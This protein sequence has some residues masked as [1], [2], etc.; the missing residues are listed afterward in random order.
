MN[1]LLPDTLLCVFS[2]RNQLVKVT[3][4][5]VPFGKGES[6]EEIFPSTIAFS[7]LLDEGEVYRRPVSLGG[8]D[9]TYLVSSSVLKNPDGMTLAVIVAL[10]KKPAPVQV[11]TDKLLRL[12]QLSQVGQLAAGMAHEVRN[13][14]A[15]IQANLQVLKDMLP[16][17]SE[18]QEFFPVIREEMERLS[19]LIHDLLHYARQKPSHFEYFS[20][21]GMWERL[22]LLN[23]GV[24]HRKM[25]TVETLIPSDFPEMYG[26]EQQIFQL[27]LNLMLNSFS[28]M[29][30]TGGKITLKASV[31][32][33]GRMEFEFSDTGTGISRDIADKVF[34]PFFTT[35][36]EGI[37]LGLTIVHKIVSTHAGVIK[38]LSPVDV[39]T[40]VH[41]SF[42]EKALLAATEASSAEPKTQESFYA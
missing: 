26:N 40:R 38:F 7:D 29:Q 24:V 32:A 14:L 1:D 12:D 30:G 16:V 8:A 11:I 6:F 25:I 9:N 28:A 13:P 39:G 31:S 15:G 23:R 17:D 19:L 27:F 18:V 5:Y 41:M 2:T 20:F 10:E 22:L 37:G 33:E 36:E 4:A 42:D 34:D 21:S 3:P 35:R